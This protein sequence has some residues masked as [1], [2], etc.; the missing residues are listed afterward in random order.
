MILVNIEYAE[1]RDARTVEADIFT[2]ATPAVV[3]RAANCRAQAAGVDG[4]IGQLSRTRGDRA[5]AS[6]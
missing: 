5:W 1:E 3:V 4:V 6:V 2:I